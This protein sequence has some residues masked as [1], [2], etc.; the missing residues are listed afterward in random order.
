MVNV[1][2]ENNGSDTIVIK[3]KGVVY[4]V[5]YTT[6]KGVEAYSQEL[7]LTQEKAGEFLEN[8]LKTH[9]KKDDIREIRV[10]E[11]YIAE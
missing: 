9:P 8:A 3:K 6:D 5:V 1:N 7:F 4:E 11:R 2:V 10:R